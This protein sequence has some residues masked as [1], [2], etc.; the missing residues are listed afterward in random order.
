MTP[1]PLARAAGRG[2]ATLL[3]LAAV[4][5]LAG[6]GSSDSTSDTGTASASA[7]APAATATA[8]SGLDGVSSADQAYLQDLYAKAKASGNLTVDLYDAYGG[9]P[10]KPVFDA[11]EKAFP[12]LKVNDVSIFG[13]PAFTR[14]DGEFASGKHEGDAI[15]SGISDVSYYTSKG[16]FATFTPQTAEGLD[17]KLLDAGLWYTPFQTSYGLVYNTSQLK[18]EDLPKTFQDLGDP[19]WKGK[20][21]TGAFVGAAPNDFTVT[22]LLYDKLVTEDDLRALAKNLQIN[23]KSVID[24]QGDVA[25]GR[26]QIALWGPQS[27][28]PALKD[29]GAPVAIAPLENGQ[30]LNGPGFGVLKGGD[31]AAAAELL[32]AYLFT[33]PAQQLFAQATF[34]YPTLSDAV[35][36]GFPARSTF[37]VEQ[38]PAPVFSKQL[39]ADKPLLASIFGGS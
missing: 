36:E 8:P 6:C 12:G 3:A 9:G 31:G 15:L 32:D 30:L 27:Y 16:R 26:Y 34:N 33:A 19:K 4:V 25:T 7:P 22:T 18:P 5:A 21:V 20:L 23:A 39:A 11:A 35:P 37:T 38:L 29:K 14:V 28:A 2:T 10:L 1:T 24:A 17:P 13:A